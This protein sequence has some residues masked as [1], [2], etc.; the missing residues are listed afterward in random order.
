MSGPLKLKISPAHCFQGYEFY[1]KIL[2]QC[3][4][5]RDFPATY[6]FMKRQLTLMMDGQ[7]EEEWQRA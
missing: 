5:Y 4:L 7:K 3:N 2:F 6:R 1:L